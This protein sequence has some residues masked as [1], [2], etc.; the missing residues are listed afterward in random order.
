L[1]G[2]V[3]GGRGT[4]M[5]KVLTATAV[6]AALLVRVSS[7]G[8]ATPTPLVVPQ[9][10]AFGYLGH[11]CGGIQEH[12][13][14]T[15]FDA[16]SGFPVG[17]T[18]VQ[19]RCGGSGRGGGYH[20]TTY[21][22]W[23]DVMWD[24]TGALVSSSRLTTAPTVD[25]NFSAYDANGN[26]IYNASNSAFLLLSDTFVP[27]PRVLGIAPAIGP[28]SGGT[29]VT[30]GGTGFTNA[31]SVAFGG[32]GATFTVNS[33]TSISATSPLQNAGTVDVTVS[34]SGGT[35][36][37]SAADQFRFV[38][39]PT[40]SG[41]SPNSGPIDGGTAITVS[42]SGFDDAAAVR[43]GDTPIGFEVTDDSTMTVVS[44]PGEAAGDSAAILVTSIGGTSANTS[45]DRFT[46]TASVLPTVTGVAPSF[47][48]PEGGTAVTITGTNFVDV[49]EVDF[50]STPTGSFTVVSPTKITTTSP[51][52]ANTVDV[53]VVTGNGTSAPVT[54]DEFSYGPP[55]TSITPASGS[56]L[57][58]T[59]V[60]IKGTDF[61]GAYDVSFGGVSVTSFTVNATGTA[62]T[63]VTPPDL[64]GA[65]AVDVTVTT[66]AG[67]GTLAGAFT[68]LAPKVTRISPT[69]GPPSGGTKVVVTGTHMLGA[70]EVDFGGT[71]A[72]I[73]KITSTSITVV[74]PPGSGKVPVTVTNPAGTSAP[75][76]KAN[77]SY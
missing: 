27:T 4:I 64:L 48:P 47:G 19:T 26:E 49:N 33:D 62:I 24:F 45:A 25:P 37:P 55:M 71:P 75:V 77:F 60:T 16:T 11:S 41:L 43:F 34:S 44:P 36:T 59:K 73:T 9:G 29:T 38:A 2:S 10:V 5:R 65:A 42:G 58:K 12:N 31:T 39:A 7:A 51:P 30:I 69:V 46:Y 74:S 21:S 18:Y 54:A 40:V 6:V 70:T 13:F 15:G 57:G 63:A 56:V 50:G 20:V 28:A 72:E 17:A 23:L 1:F 32:V 35:S 8:A 76:T 61:T 14:A 66:P 22:A 53:S 67:T 3:L 68:Y 52:G